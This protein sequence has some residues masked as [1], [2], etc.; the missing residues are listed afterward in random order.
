MRYYFKSNLPTTNYNRDWYGINYAPP[1]KVILYDDN[2]CFC[3][4]YFEDVSPI[5][6]EVTFY[7]NEQEALNDIVTYSIEDD[8]VWFGDRLAHRWN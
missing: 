8:N 7:S 5:I 4:G 2:N 3:I 6:P 1:A